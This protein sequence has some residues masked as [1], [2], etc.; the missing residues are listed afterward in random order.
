MFPFYYP[1]VIIIIWIGFTLVTVN[2]LSSL[3]EIPELIDVVYNLE[4]FFVVIYFIY[5]LI[6]EFFFREQLVNLLL[7]QKLLIINH[8]NQALAN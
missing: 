6:M 4:P 7:R 5:Y 3:A 2:V 1:G 8:K